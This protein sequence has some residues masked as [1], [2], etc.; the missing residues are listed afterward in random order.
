MRRVLYADATGESEGGVA[1]SFCKTCGRFMMSV[2]AHTCPPQWEIWD[3]DAWGDEYQI[4]YADSAQEA[5]E[6][7]AEIYDG[8]GDYP[9]TNGNEVEV[10]I[11]KQGDK[12]WI[13]YVLSAEP[14]VVYRAHVREEKH[15]KQG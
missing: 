10:K 8:D 15:G 12:E 4:I 2:V 7:Y 11:R 13:T 5:G 9:L 3:D 14:T 1:M 6:D